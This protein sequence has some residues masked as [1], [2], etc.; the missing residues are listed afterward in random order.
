MLL[1][2]GMDPLR[3]DDHT[4]NG[5]SVDSF[6]PAPVA[7]VAVAVLCTSVLCCVGRDQHTVGLDSYRVGYLIK[8][9]GIV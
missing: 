7:P 1:V 5:E 9:L 4:D 2:V 8:S 3:V 6:S